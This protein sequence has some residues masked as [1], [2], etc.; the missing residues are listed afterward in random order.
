[1]QPR[2]EDRK[3]RHVGPPPELDVTHPDA[4]APRWAP[5]SLATLEA[6]REWRIG[7]CQLVPWGSNYTFAVA[8]ERQGQPPLAAIYKPSRGEIPLWDFEAGT[9][10]Q[11]EYA[12]YLLSGL[13]GWHFIPATVI[14]DGPHGIGTVQ[15]YVEPDDGVHDREIRRA[16]ARELRHLALFD[17]LTNNAD[18]K[19]S[20]CF[21]GLADRRIWGIDHG[22]TFHVHP[23]LRTVIWD[24][25][26][27]PFD[28][29]LVA[30]LEALKRES[31]RVRATLKPYLEPIEIDMLFRRLGALRESRVFP[32]LSSRRNIPY[33]W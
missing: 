1:M 22:L 32:M 31:R 27:E 21:V 18:R 29:E 26:G 12:A 13:L 15:L 17:L 23:K 10:Y 14:R 8:L 4:D 25:C 33:G 16:Y 19:A 2:S 20:H 28:D 7:D 6:L 5:P 3:R 30:A 11:R 24:F 9:L